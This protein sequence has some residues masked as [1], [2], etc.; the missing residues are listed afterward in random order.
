MGISHSGATTL[1]CDNRSAIMIAHNDI[2]HDRTKH[3]EIDCHFIHQHVVRGT[4]RF[5]SVASADQPA[6]FF[7]QIS[8]SRMVS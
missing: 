2:F 3:I 6:D 8:F 1:S 7:Y 5:L 4:V